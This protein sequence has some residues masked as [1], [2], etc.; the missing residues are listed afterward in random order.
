MHALLQ[1]FLVQALNY[2]LDVN[3]R[4]SGTSSSTASE[5]CRRRYRVTSCNCYAESGLC[6]GSKTDGS[7]C[8]AY[9]TMDVHG[10]TGKSVSVR[11]KTRCMQLFFSHSYSVKTSGSPSFSWLQ[12]GEEVSSSEDEGDREMSLDAGGNAQD[13]DDESEKLL[14][15][16]AQDGEDLDVDQ[17]TD[18]TKDRSFANKA[19]VQ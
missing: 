19:E 12:K 2:P 7:T 4:S 13:E 8:W 11:A 9:G 18:T 6:S 10:S 17:E 14:D 3:D 5:S 16:D 1:F 15:E